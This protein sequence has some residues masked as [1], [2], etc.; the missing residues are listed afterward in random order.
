MMEFAIDR[1]LTLRVSD[2]MTKDVVVTRQSDTI[3]EALEL[4][5][6]RDVSAAPVVDDQG[7][8]VGVLSVVDFAGHDAPAEQTVAERMTRV[9]QSVS[10]GNSLLAA[11]RAM[12]SH[13]VH[14]LPVLDD[15]QPVGV[16]ST[17]DV[18]AAL[19]NAIDEMKSNLDHHGSDT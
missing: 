2:V 10:S 7:R 5:T 16:I 14:R 13:H 19:V 18:V 12:C 17:M 9:V 11:A 8:C 4:F 3:A 6:S 15:N 1:L